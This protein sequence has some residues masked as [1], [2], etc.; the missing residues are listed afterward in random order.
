METTTLAALGWLALIIVYV[1][2]WCAVIFAEDDFVWGL[3]LGAHAAALIIFGAWAI[4]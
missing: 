2:F 4:T 3:W 1:Y